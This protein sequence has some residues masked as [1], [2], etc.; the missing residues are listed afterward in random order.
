MR[1]AKLGRRH[2]RK[3]F[4][5]GASKVNRRNFGANHVMRGGIRL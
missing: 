5:K 3:M 4:R 2:S 1:R